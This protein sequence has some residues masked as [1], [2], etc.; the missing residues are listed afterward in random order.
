MPRLSDASRLR[1][2]DDIAA[3]AMRCFAREGFSRTSM[4]DIIRE[5][6]SSS[7]SVYSNFE[8]KTELVRYA[9]SG[10]LRRLVPSPLAGTSVSQTPW[11]LLSHLLRASTERTHARTLLQIWSESAWDLD[12]AEV[13]EQTTRELR[14]SI[15]EC[16]TPWSREHAAAR[17]SQGEAVSLTNAVLTALQGFIIRLAI[18]PEVNAEVLAASMVAVFRRP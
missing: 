3:A 4:A 6:G 18:D 17:E 11:D 16:L 9:A 13:T 5:A 12:L 14:S 7:G 10:A 8:N 2:R 1:R 15:Q